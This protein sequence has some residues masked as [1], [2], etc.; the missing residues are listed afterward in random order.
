MIDHLI[1]HKTI[2][3]RGIIWVNIILYR[4]DA[5]L[6]TLYDLVVILIGV[7]LFLSK[8]YVM[9]I[10]SEQILAY[11]FLIPLLIHFLYIIVYVV[12]DY[13]DYEKVIHYP[14]EKLTYYI[15]RPLISF[16]KSPAILI[17]LN[18]LYILFAFALIGFLKLPAVI[19]VPLVPFLAIISFLRS[20][21]TNII[22]KHMLFSL[23]R[24]AKYAYATLSLELL[25]LQN[26]HLY[27]F[28]VMLNTFLVPYA[29]YRTLEYMVLS[30][31]LLFDDI[32]TLRGRTKDIV[33]F[34]MIVV[35]STFIFSYWYEHSFSNI[36]AIFFVY[37]A[38]SF[39]TGVLSL[40]LS[41]F[42]VKKLLGGNSGSGYNIL[43]L[44]RLV[45]ASLTFLFALLIVY[46]I[47]H[48]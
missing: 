47:S 30:K 4:V 31:D 25:L 48:N 19:Y 34:I 14:Q 46:I 15:Y 35:L 37:I 29:I 27:S 43:L 44:K 22:L 36:V 32:K 26:L 45:D 13:V 16:D 42:I 28:V 21:C 10:V 23:L 20:K 9:H 11:F 41:P 5:F 17:C 40:I 6:N 2:S 8:T 12:N 39:P 18:F 1:D 24:L 7:T 38:C 33:L 3:N